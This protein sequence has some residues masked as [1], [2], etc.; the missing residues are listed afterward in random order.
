MDRWSLILIFDQAL[1]YE[2]YAILGTVLENFLFELWLFSQ[3][4]GVE[5]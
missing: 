4:G 3:D 5:A 1:L 2:I